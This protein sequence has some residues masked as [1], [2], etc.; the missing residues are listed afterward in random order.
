M[1]LWLGEGMK[2]EDFTTWTEYDPGGCLTV[3]EHLAHYVGPAESPDECWLYKAASVP[4]FFVHKVTIQP[5]IIYGTVGN[6]GVWGAD[7]LA[8][9]SSDMIPELGLVIV[10]GQSAG[11]YGLEL[12]CTSLGQTSSSPSALTEGEA[13]DVTIR[14]VGTL[15]TADFSG[16]VPEHPYMSVTCGDAPLGYLW[17]S[18]VASGNGFS[19]E[20]YIGPLD[21]G[22]PQRRRALLT[23]GG[24]GTRR[25]R[26]GGRL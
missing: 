3:A 13:K 22:G 12:F 9:T 14:R 4:T 25:L 18:Y 1:G 26:T 24:L 10:P 15:L 16:D 2:R 19:A 7:D 5:I 17:C 20:W 8:P 6:K 11:Q 23:G 21:I